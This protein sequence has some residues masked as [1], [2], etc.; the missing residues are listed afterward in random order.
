[1]LL[2]FFFCAARLRWRMVERAE[3]LA[4]RRPPAVTQQ[5]SSLL[6]TCPRAA[7][8][9]VPAHETQNLSCSSA[10]RNLKSPAAPARRSSPIH[11]VTSQR[12]SRLLATPARPHHHDGAPWWERQGRRPTYLC[13]LP[14]QPSP[15]SQKAPPATPTGDAARRRGLTI[16]ITLTR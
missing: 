15:P 13:F 10:R 14:R 4:R 6:T 8:T 3:R 2:P 9:H 12:V 11:D 7:A 16:T 1:M 5:H